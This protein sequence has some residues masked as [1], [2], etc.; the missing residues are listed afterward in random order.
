MWVRAGEERVKNN[1]WQDVSGSALP[2]V[3]LK[4]LY[5]VALCKVL[6]ENELIF[7]SCLFFFFFYIL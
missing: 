3:K 1:P 5:Q 2:F 7:L 4:V 6:R